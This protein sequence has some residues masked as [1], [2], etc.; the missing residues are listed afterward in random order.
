MLR[1]YEEQWIKD[2]E[3]KM[4]V[5]VPVL[6]FLLLVLGILLQIPKP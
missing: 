5:L 1:K 2:Y 4:Y 6:G 3:T